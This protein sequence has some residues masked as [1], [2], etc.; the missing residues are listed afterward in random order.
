[1]VF[2]EKLI[3]L[4]KQHDYSREQMAELCNV[5]SQSIA[6]WE[7]GE[8]FPKPD[9]LV[10]ISRIFGISLDVLLKDELIVGQ[11]KDSPCSENAVTTK[12][13]SSLYEG[14]LIK[15]SLEDD[16]ILD[17]MHIHKVELWKTDSS[18]KYWTALSFSSNDIDLPNKISKA[19]IDKSNSQGNW[20]VDFK[21]DNSKYIVLKDIVLKYRI[22]NSTE[23]EYVMSICRQK[24]IPDYQMNWGE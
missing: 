4:R 24:G 12:K 23:K 3:Y 18:P 22:G 20:F 16:S 5:S 19:I 9:K 2:T 8:N 21:L 14:I 15:E 10:H 13:T 17:I 6:K 11:I 1:M 7:S